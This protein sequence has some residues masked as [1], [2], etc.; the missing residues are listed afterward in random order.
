MSLNARN[1]ILDRLKQGLANQNNPA[2]RDELPPLPTLPR[3][4]WRARFTELLEANHADVRLVEAGQSWP[5]AVLDVLEQYKVEH[6]AIGTSED[7]ATLKA[8]MSATRSPVDVAVADQA[9]DHRDAEELDRLFANT[10]AGF[11]RAAGGLAET[12]SLVLE[13]GPQEPRQLSLVPPLHI[14]LVFEDD[15]TASFQTL[16]EQ[17]RWQGGMPTNLLLVSGPSKTADIQQTLAYGAHGPKELVV[18]LVAR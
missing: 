13:T 15:L 12:G 2:Q 1:F 11:T 10:Q 9:I 14:A 5:Q 6:L 3:D 8:V 16:V 17:Q 7:A 4:Q 18:L